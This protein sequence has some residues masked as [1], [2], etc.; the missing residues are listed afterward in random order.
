MNRQNSVAYIEGKIVL[1]RN[2][3]S[4]VEI[5]IYMGK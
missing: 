5:R 4:M 3:V 2:G 1:K